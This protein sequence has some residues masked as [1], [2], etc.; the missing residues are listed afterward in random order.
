MK[1]VLLLSFSFL[2]T[3]PA[4]P[5]MTLFTN[6]Y[7]LAELKKRY[8]DFLQKRMQKKNNKAVN[9]DMFDTEKTGLPLIFPM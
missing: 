5:L 9:S 4:G 1:K 7:I 8:K 3:M 2:T 6:P